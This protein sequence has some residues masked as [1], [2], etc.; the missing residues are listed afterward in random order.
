MNKTI[1]YVVGG[2]AAGIL[3][4]R[5][6]AISNKIPGVNGL[7]KALTRKRHHEGPSSPSWLKMDGRGRRQHGGL[8]P[9]G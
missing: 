7:K 4:E 9:S 8:R 5:M 3:I 6:T 2:I 1:L